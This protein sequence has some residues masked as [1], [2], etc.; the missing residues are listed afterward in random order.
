MFDF[1]EECQ[2]GCTG[3]AAGVLT[4]TDDYVTGTEITAADFISNQYSSSHPERES[5]APHSTERPESFPRYVTSAAPTRLKSSPGW[6][7]EDRRS[8]S[9]VVT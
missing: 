9:S 6:L 8:L 3:N 5:H 2:A 7:G 1:A 4:L